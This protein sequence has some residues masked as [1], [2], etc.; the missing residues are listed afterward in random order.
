MKSKENGIKASHHSVTEE[1]KKLA[2]TKHNDFQ[3]YSDNIC[4]VCCQQTVGFYVYIALWWLLGTSW[5]TVDIDRKS[6]LDVG[7]EGSVSYLF[8]V[9][10]MQKKLYFYKS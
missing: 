6:L 10:K 3:G 7:S 9:A 8:V 5:C 2:Q 1:E 4:I